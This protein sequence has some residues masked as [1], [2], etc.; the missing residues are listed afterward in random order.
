MKRKAMSLLLVLILAASVFAFSACSGDGSGDEGAAEADT[1]KIG[2][3][4]PTTGP[5]AAYGS[6]VVES[7]KLAAA[8]INE[9][10]GINGTEVEIFDYD[11]QADSTEAINIYNRLKDQDQVHAIIGGTISSETLAVKELA[12]AD[13]MPMLTPTGTAAEITVDAP[14]VFRACYLD[15]YQGKAAAQF[16]L[17]SLGAETAAILYNSDDAYSSGIAEAFRD[18]FNE[19]GEVTVFE[20]YT[21]NSVDYSAELTTVQNENPDIIFLPDYY[22]T[23][24]NIA[25][26][27]RDMG[28]E[29]TVVGVD[30]WDSVEID[31]AEQVEGYYFVNHFAKTD[32]AE[33]V[34]NFIQAFQDE[35]GS[36]PNALGALG[37]DSMYVMAEAISNA[38]SLSRD[39]IVAAL[40]EVEHDGV[41]GT[42]KFDEQGDAAEKNIS[43]IKLVD[44]EHV[45][46]DTVS[47]E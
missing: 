7:V 44:G 38:S 25:T 20:G 21:A 8:E 23:V 4:G 9:A 43:I 19:S 29:Q 12:V 41:T 40:S 11:T 28:I 17:D 35:Y 42:I 22:Q 16:A 46:E 33:V 2:V 18:A 31:Y 10:G 34:Q 3:F 36:E 45:L 26:Q 24:G 14:S 13:N 1:I 5:V 32:P 30:G 6:A 27:I 15:P 37:Y 47:V 39:D